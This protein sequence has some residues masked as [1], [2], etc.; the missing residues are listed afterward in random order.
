MVRRL[1]R[2]GALIAGLALAAAWVAGAI[3]SS[4]LSP[5]SP[6]PLLDGILPIQ[7][8]RWV[9]PPPELADSNKQPFAK[10]LRLNLGSDGSEEGVL[11]TPDNQLNMFFD[12][13]AFAPARGQ[14]DVLVSAEPFAPSVVS[15]PPGDLS[16]LG[17]V[18]RLQFTY[19]PSGDRIRTPATPFQV[20]LVYP[21]VP[22]ASTAKHNIAWTADG[23]TWVT[24]LRGTTSL[25]A[26]QQSFGR[27]DGPGYVAILA[28]ESALPTPPDQGS[29]GGVLK[30]VVLLVAGAS[31][32]IA[33]GW[34]VRGNRRDTALLAAH[35]REEED[36]GPD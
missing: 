30:A 29:S 33:I 8:Y 22:N 3:V 31:V 5:G 14:A 25:P 36:D 17:N 16:I 32:L 23:K 6:G 10:E 9:D 7:S 12:A 28:I 34:Y 2:E 19:Q 18:Y 13:G 15:E 26:T 27:V 35:D 21:S 1:R 20:L 4:H 24:E 11:T